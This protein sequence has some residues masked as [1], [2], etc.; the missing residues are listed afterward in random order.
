[1]NPAGRNRRTVWTVTTAPYKGAHF[2]T[3][4]PKL[5]EPC[6]LAGCPGKVCPVCGKAWE[7]VVYRTPMI[8][9]TSEKGA[10]KHRQGLRTSTSGTMIKAPTSE[11]IGFRPT[12]EHDAEPIPG[13]VLDPFFGSGTTGEVAIKHGRRF[14]GLDLS[15][16]YIRLA[17][18][19]T[20]NINVMLPL[21]DER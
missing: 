7:R 8:V 16:E 5:I 15:M 10:E 17:K 9:A 2:A 19:R 18:K 4:P 3:Y 21:G 14:V 11:T 20:T 6:I 13:I 12:C 1:M